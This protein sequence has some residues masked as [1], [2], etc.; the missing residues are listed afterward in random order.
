MFLLFFICVA[1]LSFI[2]IIISISD[3]HTWF[4]YENINYLLKEKLYVEI[5]LEKF[6][7]KSK[8]KNIFIL[9]IYIFNLILILLFI[10]LHN[11]YKYSTQNS[12]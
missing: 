4:Y 2:L 10:L 7:K 8:I 12:L 5:R 9:L 3:V 1:I 6:F 11:F